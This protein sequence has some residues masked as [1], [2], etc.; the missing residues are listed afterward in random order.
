MQSIISAQNF[1]TNF[2]T[3]IP[4]CY[5]VARL[6]RD[7]CGSSRLPITE[8]N[9]FFLEQHFPGTALYVDD[10]LRAQAGIDV[11]ICLL[12]FVFTAATGVPIPML[13]PVA[14][15]SVNHPFV[16]AIGISVAANNIPLRSLEDAFKLSSFRHLFRSNV[17]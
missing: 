9:V 15:V 1:I 11:S 5:A 16:M 13:E 10:S 2:D 6:W 4:I 8:K 14:P 3:V 12:C 7:I 17:C